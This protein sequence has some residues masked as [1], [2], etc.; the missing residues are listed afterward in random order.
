MFLHLIS[1]DTNDL[2]I[3]RRSSKGRFLEIDCSADLK[4][5][6][7][8]KILPRKNTSGKTGVGSQ[9][10]LNAQVTKNSRKN[11]VTLVVRKVRN[12]RNI[13]NTNDQRTVINGTD[14]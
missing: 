10:E 5:E 1:E 13:Q 3:Q 7:E 2:H 4:P 9:I 6:A 8:K 12:E 11:N 14:N